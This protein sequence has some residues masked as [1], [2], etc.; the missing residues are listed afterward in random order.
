MGLLTNWEVL[1]LKEETTK[2]TAASL[3]NDPSGTDDYDLRFYDT[4]FSTNVEFDEEESTY[5]TG[6][7]GGD[8]S[9]AGTQSGTVSGYVKFRWSG[10]P[11]T[12]PAIA[13]LLKA[14]GLYEHTYTDTDDVGI[15]YMN[16]PCGTDRSYTAVFFR[17]KEGCSTSALKFT[18]AGCVASEMSL[19]VDNVGG[20]AKLNFTLTGKLNSVEDVTAADVPSVNEESLDSTLPE[21]MLKT[22]VTLL[23]VTNKISSFELDFGLTAE[24]IYNQSDYTG[25]DYYGIVGMN[26]T[27]SVDPM[28]QLVA[29]DDVYGKAI[30]STTGD[31][32]IVF[33]DDSGNA[34]LTIDAPNSQ[35]LSPDMSSR[36]ERG[37][38]D[39][40]VRALRVGNTATTMTSSTGAYS[41]ANKANFEIL[42]GKRSA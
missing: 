23:G 35:Y 14:G 11:T 34:K 1:G 33:K 25:F 36:E 6:D 42:L 12:P 3:S 2:G 4:E 29:E 24:P 15:G 20:V 27:I 31:T 26:P 40:S 7:W 5:L 32:K 41:D 28:Q 37:A 19:S 18:L 9:I 13:K 8:E 10:D 38:W 30:N 22:D 16:V 17:P 21:K 39:V